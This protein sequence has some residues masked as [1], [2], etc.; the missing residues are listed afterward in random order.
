MF[1]YWT[2]GGQN[3]IVELKRRVDDVTVPSSLFPVYTLL[4]LAFNFNAAELVYFYASWG[5]MIRLGESWWNLLITRRDLLPE[6]FLLSPSFTEVILCWRFMT[7]GAERCI[8]HGNILGKNIIIVITRRLNTK[9]CSSINIFH[10]V[11]YSIQ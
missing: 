5:F 10:M 1:E 2:S 9:R 7:V 4:P 11:Q 6:E 3:S 8:A